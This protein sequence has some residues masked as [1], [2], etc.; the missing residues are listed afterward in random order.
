MQAVSQPAKYAAI[1]RCLL[2]SR[3]MAFR[4]IKSS[5]KHRRLRFRDESDMELNL[6]VIYRSLHCSGAWRWNIR[7][8][9]CSACQSEIIHATVFS[10]SE[11]V[12]CTMHM[13]TLSQ[14]ARQPASY[15]V[16]LNPAYTCNFSILT[17]K[18]FSMQS[19]NLSE[20]YMSMCAVHTLYIL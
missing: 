8:R 9:P 17:T 5:V 14:T 1:A 10:P 4:R 2:V 16:A 12:R 20:N 18:G 7:G 3:F 19:I 13:H 15:A 11:P 6:F